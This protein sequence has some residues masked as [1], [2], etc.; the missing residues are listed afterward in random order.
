MKAFLLAVAIAGYAI[1]CAFWIHAEFPGIWAHRWRVGTV[2]ARW[3][4][5]KR[6]A[7]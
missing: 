7:S 3:F 6:R 2:L 5:L 4:R 1:A